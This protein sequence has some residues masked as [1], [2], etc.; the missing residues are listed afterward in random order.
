M[1][2]ISDGLASEAIHLCKSSHTGCVIYEDKIPMNSLG[3]APA[4]VPSVGYKYKR[5]FTE[6]QI[7]GAAAITITGGFSFGHKSD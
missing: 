1:I 5:G 6:L 7:L 4:I 2:D 3:V